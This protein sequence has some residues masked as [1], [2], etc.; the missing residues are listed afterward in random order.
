[1]NNA[2][3]YEMMRLNRGQ[4]ITRHGKVIGVF[5]YFVGDDDD[6]YIHNK[7]PWEVVK[8]DSN[9]T[10]LYIDQLLIKSSVRHW[11]HREIPRVIKELR[12]EFPN[13]KQVVWSRA[14]L[15]VRKNGEYKGSSRVYYKSIK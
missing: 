5:T 2:Y 14:P 4:I 12:R 13:I 8:D 7:E 3:Y 11:I 1:M 9:G 15:E 10:K 6:K